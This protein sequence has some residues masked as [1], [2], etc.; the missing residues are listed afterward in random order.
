MFTRL[1]M[2]KSSIEEKNRKIKEKQREKYFFYISNNKSL[3]FPTTIFIIYYNE[4]NLDIPPDRIQ[5]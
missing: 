5:E 3:R 4:L 2:L 1:E